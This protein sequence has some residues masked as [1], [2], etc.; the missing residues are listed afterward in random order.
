ME[1]VVGSYNIPLVIF[2]VVIILISSYSANNFYL[3]YG[4]SNDQL[5][6]KWFL[7]GAL[8]LGIGIWCMQY[9]GIL[10]YV[11]IHQLLLDLVYIVFTLLIAIIL[12]YFSI[13]LLKLRYGIILSSVSFGFTICTTNFI[14]WEAY[15]GDVNITLNLPIFVI[16]VFLGSIGIFSALNLSKIIW[17]KYKSPFFVKFSVGVTFGLSLVIFRYLLG[18]SLDITVVNRHMTAISINESALMILLGTA[19]V[20]IL[21]SMLFGNYFLDKIMARIIKARMIEQ[22]Y[23]SLYEQNPDVVITLD[24]DGHFLSV[25]KVT[26]KYGYKEEELLNRP[27]ASLMVPDQLEK[28]V[29]NFEAAKNGQ[30]VNYDTAFLDLNRNRIE[31]NISNFPIIVN[32]QIVGVYGV[33]KDITE[34]KKAQATLAEAEDKYRSL[35]ENSVVGSYITQDGKFVYANQKLIE[36]LGYS[37]EDLIGSNVMDYVY[38]EDHRVI[39]ENVKDRINDLSSTAHYQYRMIKKDRTFLYVENFGSAMMYQGKPAAI[40]TIVDITARK[41][42]EETIEYMAFHDS[43]TGLLN[44]NTF[45]HRLMAALSKESTMSLALIYIDLD[46][47]KLINDALGHEIGDQLF[48][49]VSERLKQSV[50]NQGEMGRNRGDEFLVSLPN[51][52]EQE[53]STVAERMIASLTEPFYVDRYELYVTPSI[54]ISLYPHDSEDQEDLIKKAESAMNQAKKA[55]KND[56]QFYNLKDLEQNHERLELEMS[57]RKALEREEFLLHYQPKFDLATGKVKGVEA[58]IRWNHPTKGFVSPGDFIPLAEETG[59]IIPIGEWVIRTACEQTKAWQDA[60]LEPFEVSVNL[61]VRQLYQPN[62]V[63]MVGQ[64]LSETSLDA[65]YL[66]LEITESMM[67]DSDHALDVFNELKSLGIKISL[68]DFGTGYS[69]LHYLKEAPIDKLK[70]DQSFVRHCAGDTNDATL[71]RTIIAM[72]HQLDIEVIAEGVETVEHLIFL[73]QNLCDEAQGFLF[74]KP[75][76][77]E[78]LVQRFGDMEKIVQQ[79]GVPKDLRD[80]KWT[81]NA[82]E[83][84][85]QEVLETIRQQQGMIFK[86]IEEDGRFV[87]T[88]CDGELTYRMGLVPEQIIGRELKDFQSPSEAERQTHF[89][90]AAWEGEMNISYESEMNGVFYLTSL[91]PVIRG[92][93]VIG[94][95]GSCFDITKRKEMEEALR[96]SEANFRLITDNMLDMIEVWDINGMVKYSSP[97]H[98]KILGHPSQSFKNRQAFNL[99]HP[100]DSV[101]VQQQFENTIL[102]NELFQVE[103]RCQNADGEWVYV[104]AQGTPV[105]GE[106]RK[107]K[108]VVVAGRDI[109]ERKKM[110]EFIRKSEKLSIAGQ[111]ASDVAYEIRDPLTSIKGFLQLMQKEGIKPA[112]TNIMLSEIDRIENIINDFLAHTGPHE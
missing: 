60:G 31:V 75:I 67:V 25:N 80:R 50:P 22:Y 98:E 100:E 33:V 7:C 14:G 61:S 9:F 104:E 49:A 3:R 107:V 58:L 21:M 19:T 97:S 95:I 55:G 18:L 29:K 76:P 63:E 27:F 69:S 28:A 96:L 99:V 106:D 47:F 35:T 12:S 38:T 41:K 70:I 4:L 37:E 6:R 108:H 111:I 91:R 71:V 89:Y 112:Y 72:A 94:V 36:L 26:E 52:E 66:E 23:Q 5:G 11:P 57:L 16:A 84:A 1:F 43:L 42:A 79:H 51:I 45:S 46:E 56:Y 39:L 10:A 93:E 110:D 77:S 34:F 101:Y 17:R 20:F 86:F 85:R 87:H 53:I 62:L 88:L 92:G 105:L 15:H 13:Y 2:S 82:L 48:K 44:R 83:I 109:T 40:G 102:N 54:G 81:E 30:H 73:Q 59:L 24:L 74:S 78:E 64:I 8:V 103:F 65:K 32:N 90:R 68:D